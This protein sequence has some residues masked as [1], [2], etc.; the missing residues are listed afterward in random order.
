M[1]SPTQPQT[2]KL[3]GEMAEDKPPSFPVTSATKTS[4]LA[5]AEKKT[6][7]YVEFRDQIK[8]DKNDMIALLRKR[9]PITHMLTP[10]RLVE[11][12]PHKRDYWDIR[13]PRPDANARQIDEYI[14][15]QL[16]DLEQTPSDSLDE[17]SALF[18][19]LQRQQMRITAENSQPQPAV[20]ALQLETDTKKGSDFPDCPEMQINMPNVNHPAVSQT[21][22]IAAIN[23]AQQTRIFI[24]ISIGGMAARPAFLDGGAECNLLSA[25]IFNQIPGAQCYPIY[26]KENT[27]LRDHSGNALEQTSPPRWLP[28]RLSP[29]LPEMWEPFFIMGHKDDLIL[30]GLETMRDNQLST[31]CFK[32]GQIK[33]YVG[34]VDDPKAVIDT[35][36]SPHPDGKSVVKIKDRTR[37]RPDETAQVICQWVPPNP[38]SV[39]SPT[40]PLGLNTIS[41]INRLHVT[42]CSDTISP[43]APISVSVWNNSDEPIFLP[44]GVPLAHLTPNDTLQGHMTTD[45]VH[46]ISIDSVDSIENHLS[47]ERLNHNY[48]DD[49][50]G[51]EDSFLIQ[52]IMGGEARTENIARSYNTN[53]DRCTC[54]IKG[55]GD[56]CSCAPLY[57]SEPN[58]TQPG[59]YANAGENEPDPDE[60][61]KIARLSKLNAN[62]EDIDAPG[63]MAPDEAQPIPAIE[64]LLAADTFFPVEL[65]QDIIQF[66]RE[67]TP[68]IIS[69][70]E[71]DL[72]TS[73]V[74][75]EFEMH[76]TSPTPITGKPFRLNQIRQQQLDLIFNQLTR[77]GVFNEGDSDFSSPAFLVQKALSS[78]GTQG[79]RMVI[80]YR[81]VNYYSR[82]SQ[83]PIPNIQ[84][85]LNEMADCDYYSSLDLRAAFM[86][87]LIRPDISRFCAVTT[88]TTL[89]L[90]IRLMFGLRCAGCHF[91]RCIRYA[92]DGVK[93]AL[94]YLDDVV[95]YTKGGKAAH[96]AVI[97]EVLQRFQQYGLKVN[98]AKCT[99]FRKKMSFLGREVSPQGIQ[100]LDRHVKAVREFPRPTTINALQKLLGLA[101]WSSSFIGFYS[102][103]IA[104]LCALLRNKELVWNDE[105]EKALI[106]LREAFSKDMVRYHVDYSKPIYLVTDA[107][108]H[109][110]GAVAYQVRAFSKKDIP[111]LRRKMAEYD[112]PTDPEAVLYLKSKAYPADQT[113]VVLPP[114]GKGAPPIKPL[115]GDDQTRKIVTSS[116][117][118]MKL[119]RAAKIHDARP[120][121][122][123]AIASKS[124]D[125]EQVGLIG[126]KGELSFKSI[127]SILSM[128]PNEQMKILDPGTIPEPTPTAHKPDPGV[129]FQICPVAYTSGLFR[130]AAVNYSVHEK[131][132]TAILQA[133]ESLK[134][135]LTAVPEV[136]ILTDSAAFLHICQYERAG[137]S[138]A[139]RMAAKLASLPYK[140][141]ITHARGVFNVADAL[142][143]HAYVVTQATPRDAKVAVLIKN[144]FKPGSIVAP[145]DIIK[146]VEANDDLFHVPP[147][148]PKGDKE[149]P[150]KQ[151]IIPSEGDEIDALPTRVSEIA[152]IELSPIDHDTDTHLNPELDAER[153]EQDR[154]E[155]VRG[156]ALLNSEKLLHQALW[157]ANIAVHQRQDKVYQTLIQRLQLS[158]EPDP[159]F[160]FRGRTFFIRKGLLVCRRTVPT[161]DGTQELPASTVPEMQIVLPRSLLP[162]AIAY[163]H[164][165]SHMGRNPLVRLF[166]LDYYAPGAVRA[167]ARFTAS[168][169]LCSTYKATTSPKLPLGHAPIATRKAGVWMIDMVT[170]F[171]PSKRFDSLLV[172]IDTFSRFRLAYPANTSLSAT[173]V[174]RLIHSNIIMSFGPP[175]AISSDNARNLVASQQVQEL[176][177]FYGIQ[178]VLVSPY[179]PRS[180]GQV[181]NA[182]RWVKQLIV[183][184]SRQYGKPW[185]DVISLACFL[186]NAKPTKYYG[187]LSPM[188]IMFGTRPR[189]PPKIAANDV[190]ITPAKATMIQKQVDREVERC[191]KNIDRQREAEN[192]RLGG[193]P[194]SF[195]PGSIVL[196][197]DLRNWDKMKM[198]PRH[199]PVPYV[200]THETEFACIIKTFDGKLRP[201]H[202]RHLIKATPREIELYGT[203]PAD[204][205]M[206][207]G[208]PFDEEDVKKAVEDERLPQFWL[209]SKY[210]VYPPTKMVTRSQT[211]SRTIDEEEP[212]DNASPAGTAEAA[213]DEENETFPLAPLA[214]HAPDEEEE[215]ETD[216]EPAETSETPKPRVRFADE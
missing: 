72:G 66:I 167:I 191:A 75:I 87:I 188:D 216:A 197:R 69:K 82:A 50:P 101:N 208:E 40:A 151:K 134:D 25:N 57:T 80:D 140:L 71:Y 86:A 34:E 85:L 211:A 182:N 12:L 178:P 196:Y 156:E 162:M 63:Y 88:G 150:G 199:M 79:V 90:P 76:L 121:S 203:L 91:Q 58:A 35:R 56:P 8:K 114:T 42:I 5:V 17:E 22:S 116:D 179:S 108:I 206:A 11:V 62:D 10:D 130:G 26:R 104:P 49:V 54:S 102:N 27:L 201:A 20:T 23:S 52:N 205:R 157:P 192:R 7:V 32:D 37:L 187:H 144:P 132:G 207:L 68:D 169:Y 158:D 175:D 138:K 152:D 74:P 120:P 209:R 19:E 47:I 107:S 84:L 67:K 29:S 55:P 46:E 109:D 117:V 113:P 181:E 53:R 33:I 165:N 128:S 98:P 15:Q 160:T 2:P 202:K 48:F 59:N 137:V 190:A 185:T 94:P 45:V 147:L 135:F 65:K 174:A 60:L 64:T 77:A 106:R 119:P 173:E 171:P 213:D 30:I 28:I 16:T 44:A 122:K 105:A 133:I 9:G 215:V 4:P 204:V 143:R 164:L 127:N 123:A 118:A 198:R 129:V 177:K 149:N 161:Q 214:I 163:Y 111:E 136:Y 13:Q 180:H 100:P 184:L 24:D 39:P 18:D 41:A 186:L 172:M 126:D 145:E 6:P 183:M 81:Q 195:P 21:A 124:G 146:A 103:I 166:N 70:H 142:T 36:G 96:L 170:G 189:P 148:P 97:K 168:C 1:E 51:G 43:E 176:L 200:V 61:A 212:S 159:E 115:F 125:E 31:I 153:P 141:I 155:L 38:N 112:S 210:R 93:G 131:E 83:T 139:Q 154:V 89:Y 193:K 3:V 78:D 92:M 194:R 14:A 95:V 110:Y 73:T 99:W